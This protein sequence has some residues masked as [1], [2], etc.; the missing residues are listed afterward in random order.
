LNNAIA[1]AVSKP[2]KK[3]AESPKKVAAEAI[4]FVI[5]PIKESIPA[6]LAI[7]PVASIVLPIKKADV[8]APLNPIVQV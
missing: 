6:T 1:E 4:A 3:V 8:G 7:T 2:E 5:G